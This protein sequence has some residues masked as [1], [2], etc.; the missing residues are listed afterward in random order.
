MKQIKTHGNF[1]QCPYCN[2]IFGNGISV[3]YSEIVMQCQCEGMTEARR[4]KQKE[5][6]EKD[7]DRT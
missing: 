2:R 7:N 1:G 6:K 4:Q 3:V 5:Q